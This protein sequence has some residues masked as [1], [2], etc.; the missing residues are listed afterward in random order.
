MPFALLLATLAASPV[1]VAAMGLKAVNIGAT[2][3]TFMSDFLAQQTRS[4]G[5]VEVVT[6]TELG[7]LLGLERQ[8][9]L[10]GCADSSS[11][12]LAE[13]SGALG[14]DAVIS[15]SAAKLGDVYAMTVSLVR[16][17]DGKVLASYSEK[18]KSSGDALDWLKQIAPQLRDAAAGTRA[19][20]SGSPVRIS[21]A[22]PF[23][24]AGVGAAGF[25]SGIILNVT[26]R[27]T[28]SQ[29]ANR[30]SSIMPSEVDALIAG[31]KTQELVGN[32]CLGIGL[33]AL[34]AGVL[35][36]VLQ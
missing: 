24:V 3:A 2:E 16:V 17:A 20:S 23:V 4:P 22:L 12:C 29:I 33:A 32:L 11:S 10:L 18:L 27:S 9:Q 15:G 14:V 6:Q 25:V 26:A 36:W 30:S 7:E 35:W 21:R 19:K 31:G 13:L 5:E 8:K 1:K 28:A 34:V